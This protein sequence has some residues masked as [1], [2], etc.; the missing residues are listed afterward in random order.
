ML[1]TTCRLFISNPLKYKVRIH[2]PVKNK[3]PPDRGLFIFGWGTRITRAKALAPAGLS[4]LTL[5]CYSQPDG[6]SFIRYILVPH[7]FRADAARQH[8]SKL[9]PAILS[10]PLKC[11]VRIHFPVKN[12]KPPDRGFFIFGWGTRIRTLIDGVRVRCPAVRR[13]PNYLK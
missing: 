10:N 8:R 12:K 2:F 9:L 11:K 6:C 4:S 7:P 5:R 1:L 13:F 3:N